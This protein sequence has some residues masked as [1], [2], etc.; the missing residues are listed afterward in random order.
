M[1]AVPFDYAKTGCFS[2]AITR[3]INEDEALRSFYRYPVTFSG[4]ADILKDR[5]F[6]GDRDLLAGILSE[7]YEKTY[8][9]QDHSAVRERQLADLRRERTYTVTTG[10]Q[11]NIFTGPLYFIYKIV[12]TIKLARDLKARFPDHDFVPVY[13]MAT[14]DHDFPEIDHTT[15]SHKKIS[16]DRNAAGATGRLD[17]KGFE[18]ALRDYIGVLG[19][20]GFSAELS[21]IVEDAYLRNTTLANATR[22]LV[23]ALFGEY[24]LLIVDADDRR[25]KKQFAQVIEQDILSQKS[26]SLIS[27]QNEAM[28]KAGIKPQVHP[29]EINFFYLE[30]GLRERIVQEGDRYA[31]LHS[32][33]SFSRDELV[34]AIRNTPE[35]FS[36]NVVMRPV[37]Q[38]I[39]LPNIAYIGGGA[40][41]TYWFQ[42]KTVFEQYG[43]SYPVLLLRNSVAII[44]R[45]ISQK[46][47]RMEMDADCLFVEPDQFKTAWIK[48]HSRTDLSLSDER[49][50]LNGFF[51]R[52]KLRAYKT[53]PTLAPSTE[54]VKAR[55]DKAVNNLENKLVRAEKKRY[56]ST[57]MQIDAIHD[58]LF[59]GGSLQERSENFG[60]YYVLWGRS[61]LDNLLELFHPLGGDFTL[62]FEEEDER[63][64]TED[65]P[66]RPI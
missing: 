62:I 60:L 12:T 14:E 41:V 38:E 15:L 59:P 50:E 46:I 39:I 29:R 18:P 24:G 55:L 40:E 25:L 57:L 1:R 5:N 51:E 11:L 58:A 10:H 3:Y 4:F 56:E 22:S 17:M 44:R 27:A 49:R 9:G 43:I 64:L 65:S 32:E 31:V 36:P 42:L 16:W 21:T 28:E 54:A 61:F 37:Y 45:H 2:E 8:F 35:K 53:D 20:T 66:C 30:N 47:K 33:I 23:D 52:L 19:G 7:Q 63:V 26:F 34:A 48:K 13:W 6:S